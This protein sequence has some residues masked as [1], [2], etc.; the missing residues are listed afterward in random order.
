[1]CTLNMIGLVI[2]VL[3]DSMLPTSYTRAVISTLCIMLISI[4]NIAF[5]YIAVIVAAEL[6][7]QNTRAI[8]FAIVKVWW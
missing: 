2:F 7:P 5:S 4:V 3:N 1:M 6:L 8:G